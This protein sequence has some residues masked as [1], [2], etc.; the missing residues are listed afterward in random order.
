M[1]TGHNS[2]IILGKR[3]KFTDEILETSR[4]CKRENKKIEIFTNEGKREKLVLRF[5]R[6]PILDCAEKEED[7][8]K[9]RCEWKVSTPTNNQTNKVEENKSG[10]AVNR[11]GPA[12]DEKLVTIVD[13]SDPWS[14]IKEGE[15]RKLKVNKTAGLRKS[16]KSKTEKRAT[17][18]KPNTTE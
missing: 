12:D 8:M 7:L 9:R 4:Y 18:L 14:V 10:E 13:V 11:P 2:M 15:I 3:R 1:F 17:Y 6:C 5:S 16:S